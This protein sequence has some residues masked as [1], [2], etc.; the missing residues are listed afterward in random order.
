VTKKNI[1]KILPLILVVGVAVFFFRKIDFHTAWS[2]V[3]RLGYFAP[4]VGVPY[5]FVSLCDS[6]GWK[7]S[8]AQSKE[9][10]KLRELLWMRISTEAIGNSLP[11]GIAICETLKAI[12]LKTRLAVPVSEAAANGLVSKFSLALSH[13]LFL[14]LGVT[15]AASKLE[16]NSF[17][18]IGQ[19]GLQYLGFGVAALFLMM[20]SLATVLILRGSLMTTLASALGKLPIDKLKNFLQAHAAKFHAVDKS[21][22][23]VAELQKRQMLLSVGF[24][25]VGWFF[26][27]LEDYLIFWLLGTGVTY[28]QSLSIEAVVSVVRMIFFFI[29]SAIGMQDVTFLALMKSYDVPNSDAAAAAFI[30]IK[31]TKE[32]GWVATGYALLSFFHIKLP[33]AGDAQISK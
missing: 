23:A 7:Y 29:P 3:S 18:I 12:L 31:R 28:W 6:A 17:H 14:L 33:D 27:S 15:L 30:I 24:F 20:I 21:F 5:L 10:I 22:S 25:F 11:A 2:Y 8:F 13:G 32:L 19:S 1:F 4:L 9:K 26:A 16:E